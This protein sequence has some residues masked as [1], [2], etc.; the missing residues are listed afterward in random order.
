[1]LTLDKIADKFKAITGT[2]KVPIKMSELDA[3]ATELS[4]F[5]RCVKINIGK[6]I[7]SWT[8]PSEYTGWELAILN[9]AFR[10]VGTGSDR[11]DAEGTDYIG[12]SDGTK[13]IIYRGQ[14]QSVR[15]TRSGNTI[16][17]NGTIDS[18]GGM[19]ILLYKL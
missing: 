15:I 12:S 18:G 2:K 11:S 17:F 16:S 4:G 10:S 14:S 13:T 7:R 1:M 5:G 6:D 19:N 9:C 8:I 3:T